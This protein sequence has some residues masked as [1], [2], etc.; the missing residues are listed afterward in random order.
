MY[1]WAYIIVWLVSFFIPYII[2]FVVDIIF[3]MESRHFELN[4]RID[5]SIVFATL[6]CIFCAILFGLK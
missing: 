4:V 5:I 2:Y 3:D 6:N 1:W